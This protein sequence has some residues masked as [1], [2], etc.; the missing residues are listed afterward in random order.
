VATDVKHADQPASGANGHRAMPRPGARPRAIEAGTLCTPYSDGM[1]ATGASMPPAGPRRRSRRTLSHDEILD[2]ALELLDE[3]GIE[4]T[5]VRGIA[6]K[7][8]VAPNAVYTYYL[9]KA[10]VLA[11]LSDRILGDVDHDVFADR[12]QPWRAR[13]ESVALE[14]RQH[15]SAHP[16]AVPL[17]IRAAAMGG[18]HARALN[19][20]LLAL[21]V[22]I[23]LDPSDAARAA[24][25]LNAYVFGSLALQASGALEP[26]PRAPEAPR[27]TSAAGTPDTSPATPLTE[28]P[29][30]AGT[31]AA[32]ASADQY[33]WGLHRL[34]DG[35]ATLATRS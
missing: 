25:L 20:Q 15:L 1:S 2:A 16:S 27:P 6:G 8:G 18:P 14:L 32:D 23:G 29:A 9:D 31:V 13:L 17:M 33:V 5:S 26:L 12:S 4:A 28:T 10:A 22:D 7:V 34:L 19:E 35:L 30:P 3:G 21:F 24:Y 11:A